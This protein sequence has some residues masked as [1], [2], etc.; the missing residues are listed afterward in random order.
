MRTSWPTPRGDAL[1]IGA[2]A[3]VAAAAGVQVLLAYK[4]SPAFALAAPAAL[5]VVCVIA[6]RPLLGVYLGI[7]AVPAELLNLQFGSFGLTPSE[8]ILL[9]TAGII[10]A[11]QLFAE[12]IGRPHAAHV[13]FAL[14]LVITALGLLIA[15]DTYVVLKILVMWT[16]FLIVSLLVSAQPPKEI[17]RVLVCVAIAGAVL[18]VEALAGHGPQE[19]LGGGAEATGRATGSFTHPNQLA[20]FLV[21]A[22][23][24]ALMLGA[25]GPHALRLPMLGCAGLSI[26]GLLLT[27]TRGAIIGAVASLLVLLWWPPFRRAAGALLLLALVF[28]AVNANAL[29]HS[30]EVSLVTTRLETVTHGEAQSNP[31]IRIWK[32]TPRIIADHPLLGV[33]A[34]NYYAYSLAYG[35]SEDGE[36][37]EHAHNVPLTVAAEL[38]VVGLALLLWFFAAVGRAAW[39]AVRDTRAPQF[40]LALG[41]TA[42][43]TGLLVNSMTDYPPGANLIMATIMIEVGVLVALARRAS[44]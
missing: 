14:G 33:G 10:V 29:R 12:R 44:P 16:S 17:E 8:G 4:T 39:R 1:W 36:P 41:V 37:Y 6:L 21:L 26:T 9:T 15:V 19:L 22:I 7:L 11:R 43:L 23:P 28:A 18:S 13:A 35:L 2:V 27:L 30:R 42:A 32:T 31:R 25:R 5:A 24:P 3:A 40:P 20:F 38:G 34:G